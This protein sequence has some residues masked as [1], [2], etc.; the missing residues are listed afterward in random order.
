MPA[1]HSIHDREKVAVTAILVLVLMLAVAY[2]VSLALP[3]DPVTV[4]GTGKGIDART[5]EETRP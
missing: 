2:A 5:I 4:L 3:D 1:R